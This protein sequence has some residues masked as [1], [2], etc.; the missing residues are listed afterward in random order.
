MALSAFFTPEGVLH[1][2]YI[3]STSERLALVLVSDY[4][5]H[6]GPYFDI[7]SGT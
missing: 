2:A 4:V 5:A 7:L 3:L 1:A 6:S